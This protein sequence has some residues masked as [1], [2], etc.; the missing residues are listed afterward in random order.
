[1]SNN[2]FFIFFRRKYLCSVQENNTHADCKKPTL[3]KTH[4]DGLLG[5]NP[6]PADLNQAPGV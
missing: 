6:L 1:M 2:I 3:Q 4:H 5:Y